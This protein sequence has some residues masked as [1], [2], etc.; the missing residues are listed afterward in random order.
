[1][2]VIGT[3][4]HVPKVGQSRT[5]AKGALAIPANFGVPKG[6]RTYVDAENTRASADCGLG[7]PLAGGVQRGVR[8]KAY[9]QDSRS[10][11]ISGGI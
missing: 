1:M 2:V 8:R 9:A 10:F 6:T 5:R 11:S 3:L 7:L 4:E